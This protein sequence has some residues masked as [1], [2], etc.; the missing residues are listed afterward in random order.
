MQIKQWVFK[1]RPVTTVGPEHYEL[2]HRD[3]PIDLANNEVLLEAK[4]ISVDPYMRIQQ[5]SQRNWE[6]PFPLNEVQ[7]ATVVGQV[8]KSKSKLFKEG[9]WAVAYSGWQTHAIVHQSDLIKLDPQQAPVTYALGILGMPGRT[10]W[11]GLTEAG[12]PKPGEVVI[13]SGAAGAVGSLVVQFAKLQGT[14]VIALAGSEEKTTWLTKELGADYALNY[15]HFKDHHQ[16]AAKIR[17]ISD[18]IDIYFDNVGG[19]ITDAI[20]PLSNLRAR[21]IICGQISQYNGGLDQVELEPRFLHHLI[22]Q[23]ATIQGILARDYTHRVQ[24]MLRPVQQLLKTG[25]L[26][27]R[28]TFIDGFEELPH[29]LSML[30][31]GDNIGKLI[32]RV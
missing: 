29:A 5:S 15:K 31:T 4:Y 2:I 3:L 16:L 18:G 10:A 19:W 23:R 8:I 6:Q 24:E 32:V 13:V 26:K 17:E 22:Y 30:F 27:Y 12:K 25:K 1:K 21:I 20:I 7:Q 28:E 9:D 11:F 14:T